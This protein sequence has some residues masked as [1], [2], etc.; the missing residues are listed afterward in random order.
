MNGARRIGSEKLREHQYI[1]RYFRYLENKRAEWDGERNVEHMWEQ[2]KRPMAKSAREVYGSV[3]V[4]GKDPKSV[5]W[6]DVVKAAIEI[7]EVAWK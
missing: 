1:N 6:N 3:R 2:V 5:W 7:K 4:G